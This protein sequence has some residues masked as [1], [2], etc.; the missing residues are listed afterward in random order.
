[1]NASKLFAA[2]AAVTFAGSAFAADVA[3]A[4]ATAIAAAAQATTAAR[5][6]NVPMVLVDKSS[7]RTRAEVK[8]EA[9]QAVMNHRATA[10]GSFDWITK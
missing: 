2:V 5:N 8:A 7:G 10:A 3:G 1:M 6:L 9:V 4:N